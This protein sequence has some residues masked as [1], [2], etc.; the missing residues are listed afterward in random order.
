MSIYDRSR[1]YQ[2]ITDQ[3]VSN[4]VC[5]RVKCYATVNNKHKFEVNKTLDGFTES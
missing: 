5:V 3:E 1:K 2:V 4:E